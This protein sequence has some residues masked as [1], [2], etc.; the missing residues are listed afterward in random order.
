MSQK[1]HNKYPTIFF[2]TS[3]LISL[4]YMNTRNVNVIT[5]PTITYLTYIFHLLFP[6]SSHDWFV[7]WPW[8]HHPTRGQQHIESED[9][10]YL[11]AKSEPTSQVLRQEAKRKKREYSCTNGKRRVTKYIG[12]VIAHCFPVDKRDAFCINAEFFPS[13][14]KMPPELP[15][16]QD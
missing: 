9:V 6:A 13:S 15:Q 11:H 14:C 3:L 10:F 16:S 7:H 1:V 5:A 8:L 12:I 2:L 4:V